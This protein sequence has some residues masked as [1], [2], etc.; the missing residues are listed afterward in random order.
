MNFLPANILRRR[1]AVRVSHGA[2]KGYEFGGES[3]RTPIRLE[4]IEKE[5]IFDIPESFRSI[6]ADCCSTED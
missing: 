1:V 6:D 5:G 2:L 3:C 4:R